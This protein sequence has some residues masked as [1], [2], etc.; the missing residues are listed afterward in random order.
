MEAP[1]MRRLAILPLV[2]ALAGLTGVSLAAEVI[3][4][5]NGSSIPVR[6]HFVEDGMLHVD[7]GDNAFLAFPEEMVEKIEID[8]EI[9][10]PPSDPGAR[11]G[12]SPLMLAAGGALGS[13]DAPAVA[14]VQRQHRSER[15]SSL[16]KDEHGQPVIRPLASDSHPGK[17]RL[18]VAGTRD[19]TD[20]MTQQS[21][22]AERHLFGA[23]P[24][25]VGLKQVI[26]GPNLRKRP[27]AS[28]MTRR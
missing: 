8:G 21:T 1:F 18:A 25:R 12:G 10:L 27:S 16:E 7:L 15:T 2:L 11:N 17:S 3:Y 4:F 24:Q 19:V 22:Q 9:H 14:A 6:S 28:R 20:A 13:N 23:E 26:S 5:T